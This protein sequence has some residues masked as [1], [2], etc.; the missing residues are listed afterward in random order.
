[1][2]YTYTDKIK[3]AYTTNFDA[4]GRLRTSAPLTL[5][6]SSHR[7]RDNGLWATL[8]AGSGAKTFNTNQGVIDMNVT[9]A[10]GDKVVRETYR[11]FAYQPGKSLL[12]LN[13]FTFATGQS[14]LRQRV[15]YFGEKE[16][17]FLVL[18]TT[19]Q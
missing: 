11:V 4:F 14:G 15:G 5:F 1:M 7:Y 10:S 19:I 2:S 16:V 18:L 3:F 9:N 17:R 8:T 6:D 13:T 12:A